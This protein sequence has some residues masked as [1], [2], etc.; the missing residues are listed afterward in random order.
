MDYECPMSIRVGSGMKTGIFG[1]YKRAAAGVGLL[2]IAFIAAIGLAKEANSRDPMWGARYS[3][4]PGVAISAKDLEIV[5][6]SLGNQSPKYFSSKAKLIG[7]F[8]TRNISEGELIPVS[9]IT[10]SGSASTLRQIPIGVNKSDAPINLRIG[11]LVDLY[12]IPTKDAKSPTTLITSRIRV[13]GIDSQSQNLGGVINL[14]FS[15][16]KD[17]ILD[18]TDAIA[19]GRIVVV[20]DEI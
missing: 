18:I 16:E 1:E 6:V 15:V 17:S 19:L 12:S 11:D 4:T 13:S 2:M 5:N 14:L 20:R 3:L 10:K 7:S 8:L 9:A